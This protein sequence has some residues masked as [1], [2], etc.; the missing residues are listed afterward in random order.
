LEAELQHLAKGLHQRRR[1]KNYEKVLVRIGRR[2]QRYSRV[3]RYYDIR[4][5][6]DEASG[7]AKTLEWTRLTPPE[8]TLL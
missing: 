2:R 6:K 8:D 1:V 3:A 5:E 7:N 4:V